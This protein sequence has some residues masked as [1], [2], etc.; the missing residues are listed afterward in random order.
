MQR[1]GSRPTGKSAR[2]GPTDYTEKGPLPVLFLTPSPGIV[3]RWR[4]GQRSVRKG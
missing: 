4:S 2:N 1:E 3:R